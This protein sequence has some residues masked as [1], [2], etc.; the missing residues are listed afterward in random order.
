[1]AGSK[2]GAPRGNTNALKHGLYAKHFN[3]EQ[4]GGLKKM[5]WDDQTHEINLHRTIGEA[6]YE[7][8]L[9]QL[10]LPAPDID[11]I[12]KLANS[13]YLNTSS[14]STS[15][16]THAILNGE[17]ALGDALSEALDMVP[18]FEDERTD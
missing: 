9:N 7:L 14:I 1:M 13:L 3:D 15:A 17:E 10:S 11:K 4:R 12:T 8:F 18:P 6:I 5:A 2:G 16:K